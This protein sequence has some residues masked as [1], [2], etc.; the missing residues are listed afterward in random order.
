METT[1]V[2]GASSMLV[3]PSSAEERHIG[4]VVSVQVF[5]KGEN[6]DIQ[7]KTLR[8]YVGVLEGYSLSPGGFAFK[9]SGFSVVTVHNVREVV[10]IYRKES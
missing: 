10:E 3:I 8:K 9:I 7:A 6:G 4:K 2:L 5:Q 1:A